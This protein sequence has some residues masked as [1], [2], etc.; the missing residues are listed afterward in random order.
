MLR[1]QEETYTDISTFDDTLK[2]PSSPTTPILPKFQ[3]EVNKKKLYSKREFQNDYMP[4]ATPKVAL[5]RKDVP[6]SKD[7]ELVDIVNGKSEQAE[8]TFLEPTSGDSNSICSL[9]SKKENETNIAL[10]PLGFGVSFSSASNDMKFGCNGFKSAGNKP[11]PNVSEESL[12]R[13]KK[14]LNEF[15]EN[16]E[17]IC[18]QNFSQKFGGFKS[19]SNKPLSKISPEALQR[20]SQLIE[21]IENSTAFKNTDCV[22]PKKCSAPFKPVVYNNPQPQAPTNLRISDFLKLDIFSSSPETKSKVTRDV[23]CFKAPTDVSPLKAKTYFNRQN[24]DKFISSQNKVGIGARC[25]DQPLNVKLPT[26][27]EA[28]RKFTV[29]DKFLPNSINLDPIKPHNLSRST[30]VKSNELSK[31]QLLAEMSLNFTSKATDEDVFM[32]INKLDHSLDCESDLGPLLFD[33][34]DLKLFKKGSTSKTPSPEFQSP[35]I[36][37][38]DTKS[39]FQDVPKT[40]VKSSPIKPLEFKTPRL[41]MS[42]SFIKQTISKP[43]KS[44]N[45]VA[46]GKT[47]PSSLKKLFNMEAKNERKT[48]KS[49]Y[50]ENIKKKNVPLNY[51]IIVPADCESSG[52]YKFSKTIDLLGVASNRIEL[53]PDEAHTEL[54]KRGANINLCTKVWVRNHYKQ[55][56]WKMATMYRTFPEIY[57]KKWEFNHVVNQL[58]YRYETEVNLARSPVLKMIAEGDYPPGNHMILKVSK[59]LTY[60]NEPLIAMEGLREPLL[61]MTDGWY[62]L[63]CIPDKDLQR[64][65]ELGKIYAGC[66]LRTCCA[67]LDRPDVFTSILEARSKV[68]LRIYYNCTRRARPWKKLGLQ[69]NPRFVCNIYNMS[70]SGPVPLV[71]VIVVCKYEMCYYYK[72]GNSQGT[73]LT[74]SAMERKR[75]GHLLEKFYGHS[76]SRTSDIQE[77]S[78]EVFKQT[79]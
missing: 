62:E 32:A 22:H 73:F 60:E 16:P 47:P 41:K 35:Q 13:A 23:N 12:K 21:S 64:C 4:P 65:I 57:E 19:A 42:S 29:I 17:K 36:V 66:K 51:S 25:Y 59:I 7:G 67:T 14:F 50:I 26:Q 56:V 63:I 70:G 34:F 10:K 49:L 53:G 61:Q 11:L 18:K 8:N 52:R 24:T 77:Q 72:E 15:D 1:A 74:H 40:A 3:A 27:V 68:K 44:S 31:N 6:L 39:L 55:I 9:G 78:Y 46:P 75:R 58:C 33:D 76:A 2:C 20:S 5:K 45:L 30:F 37:K 43:L 28:L 69:R 38:K 79:K 48:L 54:L 71:D